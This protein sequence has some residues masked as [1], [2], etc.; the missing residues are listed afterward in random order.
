V[1]LT[2]EQALQVVDRLYKQL[3]QRRP[4]IRRLEAYESGEHPLR[5]GT[6]EWSRDHAKRF[7]GWSDNWCGV[8]AQAPGERRAM[9]GFRVGEDDDV[10]SAE[11]KELIRQWNLNEMPSQASQG[12]LTAR[13]A[14]R[15]AVLVWGDGDGNPVITW[16]H[17]SQVIV[18]YDPNAPMQAR[19]ALKAWLD[20]D[21]E[22]ATLYT[23]DEVW[24]YKRPRGY[25]Q[26][27]RDESRLILPATSALFGNWSP[28]QPDGDDSWPIDNPMGIVPVQ[29]VLNR[30]R[31]GGVPVSDI[32]GTTSMQDAINML[33][34]YL[35]VA[36][37][38]ASMPARVVLGHS[39]PKMPILN[40]EGVKIG[41]REIDLE[42]LEKGR[43]L[44]LTGQGGD[45]KQWDAAKLDVFTDVIN[46]AVKHVASQTRTPIHYIVGDLGN[47]NGETLTATETPLAMKV[48][49]SNDHD[50]SAIRGTFRRIALVLGNTALAEACRSGQVQ[51]RNPE[52]RSEA[53]LADAA[54]KDRAT[55]FPIMW[56]AKYRYGYTQPQ[57]AELEA[58]LEKERTD[59]TLER[60]LR[61]VATGANEVPPDAGIGA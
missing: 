44:W 28:R 24:K 58:M 9:D 31:L 12:F 56:I 4:E 38:Y 45:I 18:D 13:V 2:A 47:V 23:P 34:K 14:K 19:Y 32:S 15:S 49:E 43:L 40:E 17:P 36:A 25:A 5:L 42:A 1:A 22:N 57:L 46:I 52:I 61:G 35:F 21:F 6:E 60:V 48:R 20:D 37:D 30:P 59:P 53:Q 51:W 8:V 27:V 7:Q 50:T 11:E 39:P 16:E 41:E 3:T 54:S 33:W 55:G 26:Q 10:I 29:E